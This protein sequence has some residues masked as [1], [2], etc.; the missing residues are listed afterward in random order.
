VLF[1]DSFGS[2]GLGPQCTV[3]QRSARASR[4]RIDD[5]NVARQW[6]QSQSWVIPDHVSLI[7]WSNGATTTLGTVAL[8]AG[9]P[10]PGPDFHSAVALYAGCKTLAAKNWQP[11]VPTLMLSGGA[12]D[13]TPAAPCQQMAAVAQGHGVPVEIVVYPGAYHDFD[14]PNEPVHER[15]GV[16][17]SGDGSGVVHLGTNEAARADAI[18]RVPQW[19]AR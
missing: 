14:A 3:R 19:L 16:A 1:P 13:W 15:K 10:N 17:F 2:R 18:K 5:A 11:R 7:G 9:T 12:D 4:E 6:L 8:A